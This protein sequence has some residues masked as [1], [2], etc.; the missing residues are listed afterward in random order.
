LL[1]LFWFAILPAPCPL[2]RSNLCFAFDCIS[3]FVVY[4]FFHYYLC[5]P[6]NMATFHAIGCSKLTIMV[7]D[8]RTTLVFEQCLCSM[9][10]FS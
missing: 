5:V 10:H 8:S 3:L 2:K 1:S 9:F 6:S 4:F 7:D